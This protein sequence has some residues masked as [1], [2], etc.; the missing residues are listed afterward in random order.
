MIRKSF[1][2]SFSTPASHQSY[3]RN[4]SKPDREIVHFVISDTCFAPKLYKESLKAGCVN[5]SFSSFSTAASH[6]SYIRNR[7]KP[8]PE[9]VHFVISDTCFAPKLYKELLKAGCVNR[10]FSSFSTPASHQSYI[11]NRSK[12]GSEILHF[13][14]FRHMFRIKAI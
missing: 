3:I 12:P 1:I 5:R 13:R 8:D 10:S 2:S 9:I 6:Q 7:S 11:R 4:R 14:H